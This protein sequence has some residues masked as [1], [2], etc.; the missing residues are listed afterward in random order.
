MRG[1]GPDAHKGRHYISSLTMD[2]PL[3]SIGRRVAILSGE[4]NAWATYYFQY[5]CF[6]KAHR[7]RN[8]MD[9]LWVV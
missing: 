1:T 4:A 2:N 3:A 6:P 5:T 9:I 8:E 7:M